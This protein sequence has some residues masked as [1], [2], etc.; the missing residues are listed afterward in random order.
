[1]EQIQ[2]VGNQSVLFIGEGLFMYFE[3][4]D[5]KDVFIEMADCFPGAEVLFEINGPIFGW[6]EQTS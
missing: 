3:E 2:G 6:Q 5:V 1:M 4:R